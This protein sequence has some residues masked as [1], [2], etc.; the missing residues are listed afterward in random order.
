MK[1]LKVAKVKPV[2]NNKATKKMKAGKKT[3]KQTEV[4]AAGESG[5]VGFCFRSPN[6]V[7]FMF[8]VT[9]YVLIN[10]D[11][12]GSITTPLNVLANVGK[13]EV[14]FMYRALTGLQAFVT[15]CNESS[16]GSKD[17][18]HAHHIVFDTP[19]QLARFPEIQII[20]DQMQGKADWQ[21]QKAYSE[22]V[23]KIFSEYTGIDSRFVTTLASTDKLHDP[24][25]LIHTDE[26]MKEAERKEKS[27]SLLH[28]IQDLQSKNADKRNQIQ[29]LVCGFITGQFIDAEHK[30]ITREFNVSRGGEYAPVQATLIS[31]K[32]DKDGIKRSLALLATKFREIDLT[33]RQPALDKIA[34]I[35]SSREYVVLM[36]ALLLMQQYK[37]TA[38]QASARTG[39][40]VCAVALIKREVFTNEQDRINLA[41]S[42][43]GKN[44]GA[45]TLVKRAQVQTASEFV[46]VNPVL[47]MWNRYRKDIEVVPTTA[48]ATS[49]TAATTVVTTEAPVLQDNNNNNTGDTLKT[50]PA[51]HDNE[52]LKHTLQEIT[53][54]SESAKQI[55]KQVVA[56]K[57]IAPGTYSLTDV[58][59]ACHLAN[60][61]DSAVAILSMSK[62]AVT[63]TAPRF[64]VKGKLVY[65]L[66]AGKKFRLHW[67]G[68]EYRVR[69]AD[70]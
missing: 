12:R 51:E 39:A 56:K 62:T 70:K 52:Q 34:H 20:D 33:L 37:L 8:P 19:E 31:T 42:A 3:Q 11:E 15:K 65:K 21:V 63:F 26:K 59:V 10:V 48:A 38:D 2:K 17:I 32:H 24:E 50:N 27:Q 41:S 4:I 1:K 47:R 54:R 46:F 49:A 13:R 53:T 44:V 28:V 60:P 5:V 66:K 40:N 9:K 45:V 67:R 61:N 14:V 25:D 69:I 57:T 7:R 18:T 23:Q 22:R 58:V 68:Q 35:L 64:K 43:V 6:V 16:N 30:I 55:T 29:R 36:R